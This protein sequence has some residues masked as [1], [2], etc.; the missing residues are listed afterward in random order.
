MH[1][2]CAFEEG[3]MISTCAKLTVALVVTPKITSRSLLAS[4]FLSD[5]YL[6]TQT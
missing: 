1:F 3:S 6:L 5:V 4:A 2:L